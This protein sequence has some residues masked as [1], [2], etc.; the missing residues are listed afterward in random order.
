MG[1]LGSGTTAWAGVRTQLG[2]F[3]ARPA[4]QQVRFGHQYAPRYKYPGKKHKGRVPIHTGGSTKGTTLQFGDYG[5]R[6]KSA[7]ERMSAKQ[8]KEAESVA[9]RVIRPIADTQLFTRLCANIAVCVK[10]N[11]TRMG[12]G[13]GAFDHWAARV[14]TGKVI[15]EIG[16]PNLHEQVAKEALR[17]AAQ[18]LPGVIEFVK[19]DAQPKLG[20]QTVA[21]E[22]GEN[23][24]DKMN[25]APNKDWAVKLE[26]KKN[27]LYRL[28]SGR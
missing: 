22:Q 24:F 9:M 6:L 11:E 19:R 4:L 14:A 23:V 20:F 26:A 2:A 1:L 17:L 28:Y 25:K 5:I 27:A 18:K 7:G 3:F 12:K 16:G 10:G 8:L 15:L 21:T 13:K